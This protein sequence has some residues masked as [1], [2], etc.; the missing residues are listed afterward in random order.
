M[1]EGE[2]EGMSKRREERGER[3]RVKERD[4]MYQGERE[5][6]VKGREKTC[7]GEREGMLK[8]RVKVCEGDREGVLRGERRCVRGERCVEGRERRVEGR[9]RRVEG[10]ERR[11]RGEKGVRGGASHRP[12]TPAF[13]RTGPHSAF[14]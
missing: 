12:A 1:C 9:E 10:R 14:C 13:A 5:A 2:R 4:K 6:C 11:V 8:E 3:G 7:E